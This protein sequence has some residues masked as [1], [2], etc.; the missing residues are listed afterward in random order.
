MKRSALL[1]G[2]GAILL[3][4]GIAGSQEN[5][6]TTPAAVETPGRLGIAAKYPGDVGIEN[7]PAVVFSDNFEGK[8]VA[9]LPESWTH[10]LNP[11]SW[12]LR[13]V[14]DSTVLTPGKRCL[15]MKATK[16]HDNGGHLWL[17]MDQGYDKLYA[18]FYA[19]FAWDAPLRTPLCSPAGQDRYN[20][21]VS[22]G[23]SRHQAIR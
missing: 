22:H 20:P 2:I 8:S 11:D 13:M 9:D 16:G 4:T 14:N 17:L 3:L 19:K 23:W 5:N 1:G 15:E 6:R 10:I 21:Q 7:D 18:R 12:V